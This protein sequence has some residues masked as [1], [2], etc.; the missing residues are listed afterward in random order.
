M[1]ISYFKQHQT[2]NNGLC[3]QQ[4]DFTG[5]ENFCISFWITKGTVNQGLDNG[6]LPVL[7]VLIA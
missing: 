6:G 2:I 3:T 1:F 5:F 4:L 7:I